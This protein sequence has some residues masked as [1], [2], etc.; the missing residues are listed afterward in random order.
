MS[1]TQTDLSALF[2]AE[3]LLML[4]QRLR[5]ITKTCK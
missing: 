2:H 1:V 5:M 4:G 3:A